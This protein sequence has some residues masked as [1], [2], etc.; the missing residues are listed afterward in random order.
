MSSVCSQCHAELSDHELP[1]TGGLCDRCNRAVKSGVEPAASS[2]NGSRF[3]VWKILPWIVIA[4]AFLVLLP[5]LRPHGALTAESRPDTVRPLPSPLKIAAADAST[6][7]PTPAVLS[8]AVP[9][10]LTVTLF[11]A[12]RDSHVAAGKP[13][14]ISAYAALAPGDSASLAVSYTRDGGPKSLL[15]LAQGSL[16][17]T[18]WT[19]AVPGHYRF[20]A[21]AFGSRKTSAIS[22]SLSLWVDAPA[23][24]PPVTSDRTTAAFVRLAPMPVVP[25]HVSQYFAPIVSSRPQPYHVA[26]ATLPVSRIAATLA[27]ALCRRGFHAFVRPRTAGSSRRTYTVETGD[28][29]RKA[30][31]QKQV[32]LLQRDGYPAYL[33][34]VQ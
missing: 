30:D 21:S 28:Y 5:H 27:A 6:V 11:S 2:E 13:V 34:R 4:A 26:A 16:S 19:P 23:L 32:R 33:F 20:L 8:K 31:A 25:R 18:A 1:N 15:S 7:I 9:V 12:A 10:P 22:H 24:T 3:S 14:M 29:L 17:S